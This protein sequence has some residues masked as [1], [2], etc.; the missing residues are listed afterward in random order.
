MPC[1]G[2]AAGS[3]FCGAG[4]RISTTAPGATLARGGSSDAI[5]ERLLDITAGVIKLLP[6]LGD[7][8]GARAIVR[9][10]ERCGPSAGA[11]YEEAR[12]AESSADFVYKVRIALKELHEARYWLKL[13]LRAGLVAALATLAP[14][15]DETSQLIAILTA[16]ASTAKGRSARRG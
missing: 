8:P 10:L 6:T 11:N 13:V 4:W 14:L 2:C 15:I 16:S 12:G 5:A 1:R 7:Q 3:R 9:Q